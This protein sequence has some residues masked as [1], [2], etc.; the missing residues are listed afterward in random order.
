MCLYV[1]VGGW[2]VC[3]GLMAMCGLLVVGGVDPGAR[4][5]ANAVSGNAPQWSLGASISVARCVKLNWLPVLHVSLFLTDR[6]DVQRWLAPGTP[7]IVRRA[8]R[9]L[10]AKALGRS[11][12]EDGNMQF[13]PAYAFLLTEYLRLLPEPLLPG[14]VQWKALKASGRDED[15]LAVLMSVPMPWRAVLIYLIVRINHFGV[16]VFFAVV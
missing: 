11:I 3:V 15:C 6:M 2:V 13:A 7:S 8:Q 5:T 10:Q 1:F 16:I 9:H 4:H 12:V 14:A